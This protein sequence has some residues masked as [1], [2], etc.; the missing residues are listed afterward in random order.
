MTATTNT[1]GLGHQFKSDQR[2]ITACSE[3]IDKALLNLSR[4]LGHLPHSAECIHLKVM[5]CNAISSAKDAHKE[6]VS[7]ADSAIEAYNQND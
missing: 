6:A 1:S 2:A 7:L 3:E 4:S 5:I